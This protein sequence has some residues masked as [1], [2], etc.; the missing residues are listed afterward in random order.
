MNWGSLKANVLFY[1][2]VG[3]GQYHTSDS[4]M[5]DDAPILFSRPMYREE[6]KAK[7]EKNHNFFLHWNRRKTGF[8]WRGVGKRVALN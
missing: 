1:I 6:E 8:K 7:E 2:M 5:D 3:S 4:F